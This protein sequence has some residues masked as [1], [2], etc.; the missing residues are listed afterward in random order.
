MHAEP[1]VLC[2]PLAHDCCV[3][4]HET[5]GSLDRGKTKTNQKKKVLGRGQFIICIT[6]RPSVSFL[7]SKSCFEGDKKVPGNEPWDI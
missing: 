3:R 1:V 2:H 6:S 4:K 7:P 5:R